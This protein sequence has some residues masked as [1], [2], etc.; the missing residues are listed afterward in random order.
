MP[1]PIDH[2]RQP[3]P[4]KL[5]LPR[6]LTR[7]LIIFLSCCLALLVV[8]VGILFYLRHEASKIYPTEQ[9]RHDEEQF[10]TQ[11]ENDN[12]E[13]EELLRPTPSPSPEKKASQRK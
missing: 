4:V 1:E 9:Q 2:A 7:G 10:R 8:L 3:V 13:M 11:R 12:R 6:W 5:L